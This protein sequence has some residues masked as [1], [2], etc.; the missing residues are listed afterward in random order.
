MTS[1]E[2]HSGVLLTQQSLPEA[3][4]HALLDQETRDSHQDEAD[5]SVD[6]HHLD[7]EDI[8]LRLR[9]DADADG[10]ASSQR[11]LVAI[12]FCLWLISFKSPTMTALTRTP[13]TTRTRKSRRGEPVEAVRTKRTFC[14]S[15]FPTKSFTS[16]RVGAIGRLNRPIYDCQEI[17]RYTESNKCVCTRARANRSLE[18]TELIAGHAD[19][20]DFIYRATCAT[21][22]FM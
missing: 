4:R 13:R 15:G 16:A 12:E 22:V 10:M 14:T 18:R 19:S 21:W 1:P 2:D 5:V 3:R 9:E 11:E 20:R 7:D 8:L 6:G 17:S